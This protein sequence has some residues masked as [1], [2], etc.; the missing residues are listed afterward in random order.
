[1]HRPETAPPLTTLLHRMHAAV[2]SS[3]HGDTPRPRH[4]QTVKDHKPDMPRSMQTR[5]RPA[6]PMR[7]R[8]AQATLD[9]LTQT[10][11]TRHHHQSLS[12]SALSLRT[13]RTP[14]LAA[15]LRGCTRHVCVCAP[16]GETHAPSSRCSSSAPN[17]RLH[18][19]RRSLRTE[20]CAR[21][22][23]SPRRR[24]L[25]CIRQAER[26]LDVCIGQAR[27]SLRVISSRHVRCMHRRSMREPLGSMQRPAEA[28]GRMHSSLECMRSL[29]R[30]GLYS[31][32]C[33]RARMH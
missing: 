9:P 11:S 23:G 18:I 1:M 5:P 22:Y 17:A 12:L 3:Q 32:A 20:R 7:P 24:L 25:V 8:D 29:R 28:R 13:L 30:V 19:S 2:T 14:R 10:H 4:Q 27:A 33:I 15:Y 31:S 26:C 21:L 6:P 16:P